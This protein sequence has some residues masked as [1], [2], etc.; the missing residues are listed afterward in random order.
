MSP[1]QREQVMNI[2]LVVS[3]VRVASLETRIA[4]EGAL[5][6]SKGST[7]EVGPEPLCRMIV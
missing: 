6:R 3:T 1:W 7:S 2:L 4:H 5:A